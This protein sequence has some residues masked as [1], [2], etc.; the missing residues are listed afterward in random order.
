[1]SL[2]LH[3]VA[4]TRHRDQFGEQLIDRAF[5]LRQ[6]AKRLPEKKARLLEDVL[7]AITL[8]SEVRLGAIPHGYVQ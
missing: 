8:E 7:E 6:V 4:D 2:G 5:T 3:D 1:M